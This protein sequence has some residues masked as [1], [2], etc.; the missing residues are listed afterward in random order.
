MKKNNITNPSD[1]KMVLK[2][3]K[4]KHSVIEKL[5]NLSTKYNTSIND[6]INEYIDYTIDN[7][8]NE[9]SDDSKK[10]A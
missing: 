1:D 2:S 3:I 8:N 9:N 5:E 10:V 7:M 6:L 4:L